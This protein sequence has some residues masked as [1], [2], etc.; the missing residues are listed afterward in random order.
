MILG[1]ETHHLPRLHRSD[2]LSSQYQQSKCSAPFTPA[3][4]DVRHLR[5]HCLCDTYIEGSKSRVAHMF[6]PPISRSES[7]TLIL[8]FCWRM[9]NAAA[10][11]SRRPIIETIHLHSIFGEVCN[12]A[13]S[14]VSS[15]KYWALL[16]A[17]VPTALIVLQNLS[18]IPNFEQSFNG[19]NSAKLMEC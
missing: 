9:L 18:E 8:V 12:E 19:I 16:F 4:V 7:C 5:R 15:L 17:V 10:H 2:S 13:E 6:L 1:F 14:R 3:L 11:L